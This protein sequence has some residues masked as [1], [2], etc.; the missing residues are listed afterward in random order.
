V[1]ALSMRWIDGFTV[2]TVAF[3]IARVNGECPNA[4][5]G[6]GSCERND[7][8]ECFHNYQGNDC[9]ERTCYFG[10]AH[11]D[12][13]KGDLNSDGFVSGPLTT[14]ITGSEVYPWGTTE[15]YPNADANEGHFYMECSNKGLC[16]RK[17]G[18]CECFPGFE[19]TACVRASCPNDCSGHGTCESIKELAEMSSFDTTVHDTSAAVPVG[20]SNHHSFDSSIEESYA[21][22]LWDQD[23]TMGCKCDPVY[24]G[25]D[26]SLRKCKYGV[27]PLFYDKD[28]G[29][30][31]QTTVIHLGSKLKGYA[32]AIDGFFR[33][34]FYDVFGEK[35]VT[36]HIS[37]AASSSTASAVQLALQ[38]LPNGVISNYTMD[39]T[40]GSASAVLVSKASSTGALTDLYSVGAGNVG[41]QGAGVGTR[42]T[43]GSE[44]TVTFA[45]NPGVLKSIELDV[46][47]VNQPGSVTG[48]VYTYGSPDYWVAN[49]RQGQFSTRYTTAL[50][51]ANTLVYG[52][53]L[54]Y[55]SHDYSGH[56]PVGTMIKIAGQEFRV[57]AT[58]D[59]MLTLNEPYLGASQIPVLIDTGVTAT[60]LAN[61]ELTG[62]SGIGSSIMSEHLEQGAH[63]Y[64]NSCPLVSA[65][66]SVSVGDN[67]L[68]VES[69]HDC[70]GTYTG[71]QVIYRR[72]DDPTNLWVYKTSADTGAATDPLMLTRGSPDV[73]VVSNA[74]DNAGNLL[75]AKG[76]TANTKTFALQVGAAAITANTPLFINHVGPILTNAVTLNDQTLVATSTVDEF[77]WSDIT[78]DNDIKFPIFK[79]V[80]DTKSIAAGNILA[81]NGRRYKVKEVAAAGGSAGTSGK[82]TLTENIAGA[83]LVYV[84]TKCVTDVNAAGTSITTDRKVTL[85]VSEQVLISSKVVGDLAMTVV[86][87]VN[88]ATTITTSKGIQYG[89]ATNPNLGNAMG[90]FAGDNRLDLLKV[91]NSAPGYTGSIV[92]ESATATTFQYVSQCANRGTCD[93]SSGVC[94]CFKG[95]AADN[96]AVA[97]MLAA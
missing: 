91:V 67:T 90:T 52:S 95:Y 82:I 8:C 58:T 40:D 83:G 61:N 36:K 70:S 74:L 6:H 21:Y 49:T 18:E 30:I 89:S 53:K 29:V 20:S 34:V 23:K 13:P 92:T 28:A 46:Q 86:T 12:T 31:Y 55:T 62:V 11:V 1:N 33:I 66:T 41:E 73:Y 65:D 2:V 96:C 48:G 26:C 19:G 57:A 16:D 80:D 94:K 45:T 44:F 14:V 10:I 69:G 63:L 25:A 71:T 17:T 72:D 81:L 56:A 68:A 37:A 39:T 77:F 87:A 27:D 7:V 93:S 59:Y 47:Q 3:S 50:G 64:V 85:A 54:L 76:Y 60:A 38:A 32:G 35:Y 24:Y 43:F 4:C 84:C 78:A 5:S 97:N 15:Q 88:D 42:S 9:S 51:R 22:N 79:V 75:Q